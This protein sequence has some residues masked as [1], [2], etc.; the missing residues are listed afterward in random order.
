[1]VNFSEISDEIMDICTSSITLIKTNKYKLSS[2][3]KRTSAT[4]VSFLMLSNFT[5]CSDYS[6]Q[7]RNEEITGDI[8]ILS[9]ISDDTLLDEAFKLKT[10]KELYSDL[11]ILESDLKA[12]DKVDIKEIEKILRRINIKK[13]NPYN[14]KSFDDNIVNYEIL[15]ANYDNNEL[16]S[17]GI[18][19]LYIVCETLK[20]QKEDFEENLPDSTWDTVYNLS[21]LVIKMTFIDAYI[22]DNKN[23]NNNLS[24]IS[25]VETEN[26]SEILT[27]KNGDDNEI[28]YIKIGTMLDTLYDNVEKLNSDRSSI[29]IDDIKNILNQNKDILVNQFYVT[30]NDNS[31]DKL[32]EN[33]IAYNK[34][35]SKV[36][37]LNK[38]SE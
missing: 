11:Q 26:G 35:S 10:Y 29:T 1:M 21:Q 31:L 32:S 19:D 33:H 8:G 37:V 36:R 23:L 30:Y 20:K 3:L 38:G 13:Q 15:K 16:S 7:Y 28:Y 24:N 27:L 22:M 34:D 18:N 12:Y 9:Q 25:V 6:K 14:N 2:K 4:F 5:G 17:E